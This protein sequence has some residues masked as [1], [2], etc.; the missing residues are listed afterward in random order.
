MFRGCRLPRRMNPNTPLKQSFGCSSLWTPEW[1]L[2][3]FA[4]HNYILLFI[5]VVFVELGVAAATLERRRGLEDVPQRS[6]ADLTAGREM[7]ERVDELVALVADVRGSIAKRRGLRCRLLLALA[8][9][10]VV[11]QD[12]ESEKTPRA[13]HLRVTDLL[14]KPVRDLPGKSWGF[15]W[16]LHGTHQFELQVGHETAYWKGQRDG[17]VKSAGSLSLIWYFW[18]ELKI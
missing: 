12:L 10:F 13:V 16:R 4:G 18:F 2:L 7:V 14:R 17:E 9:A 3:T 8:L 5:Q 11:V 15:L 6:R 1:A